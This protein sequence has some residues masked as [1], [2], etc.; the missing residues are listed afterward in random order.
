MNGAGYSP[1]VGCAGY[2]DHPMNERM[3]HVASIS[4]KK[5]CKEPIWMLFYGTDILR[6][7]RR[8]YTTHNENVGFRRVARTG[9]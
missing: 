9:P 1:R 5:E 4:L 8:D 3:N 7:S 2:L 6:R